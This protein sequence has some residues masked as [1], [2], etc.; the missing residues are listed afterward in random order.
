M[1]NPFHAPNIV[2]LREAFPLVEVRVIDDALWSAKGDVN[3]AFELLLAMNS[4]NGSLSPPP[5]PVRRSNS[6]NAVIDI[7]KNDPIT[8]KHN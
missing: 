3:H 1:E 4:A 5:L 7:K 2:I 8:E 6:S